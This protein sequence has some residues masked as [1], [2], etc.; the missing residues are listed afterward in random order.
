MKNEA[1]FFLYETVKH[2]KELV[3]VYQQERL[4]P[5]GGRVNWYRIFYGSLSVVFQISKV[6]TI[7]SSIPLLVIYLMSVDMYIRYTAKDV[8]RSGVCSRKN[9]IT[10]NNKIKL[11]STYLLSSSHR[12]DQ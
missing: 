1:T 10:A 7:D 12:A 8:Y 5:T 11:G 6:Y 4:C 9:K 2:F 3:R